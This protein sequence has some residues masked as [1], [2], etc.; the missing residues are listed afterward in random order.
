MK[1]LYSQLNVAVFYPVKLKL[2]LERQLRN[3]EDGIIFGG[4]D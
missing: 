4:C 1:N 2:K 3:E